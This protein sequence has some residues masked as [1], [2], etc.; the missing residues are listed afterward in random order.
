MSRSI[1]V[2]VIMPVYNEESSIEHGA[3][4]V[5]EYL[6]SVPKCRFELIIIESGSTDGTGRV[7]D[8]LAGRHLEVQVIHE[9]RRSGFANAVRLG[10]QKASMDWIWLI[11]PDLP[12]PLTKFGESLPLLDQYDAVLSYRIHDPR[13]AM[14]KVQSV[15]FNLLVR[16]AFGLRQKHINSAFKLLQRSFVQ[17]IQ[18]R[19]KGWTI[20]VEVLWALK[21]RKARVIEIPVEIYDRTAGQSKIGMGTAGGVVKEL[22]YLWKTRHE[23]LQTPTALHPLEST[24]QSFKNSDKL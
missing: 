3:T 12:F 11:T 7:A 6:Q 23:T 4:A 16:T 22:F 10:Y 19:S 24:K 21:M 13:S 1:A 14:R 2:S 15:V 8:T 18:L 17:S 20:D 5:V 9:G